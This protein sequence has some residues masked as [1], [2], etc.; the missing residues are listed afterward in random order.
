MRRIFMLD[1]AREQCPTFDHL[2][3]YAMLAAESGYDAL[4]L[5][6]EHRF[7]FACTPWA[8]GFGAITPSMIQ[9]LQSEFPSLEII[10]FIN[11]LGHM[12]GFMRTEE[13]REF[14]EAVFHGLQ[15][16]P[17]N[18]EFVALCHQMVEEIMEVF[19]SD[20]I[21]LGGDETAQLN[22][23][24]L[25]QERSEGKAEDRKAWIYAQHFAPLIDQVVKA[26][27]TPAIWADMVLEHPDVKAML[28]PETVLFDWQ[29]ETGVRETSSR[30][31]GFR[32]YGCPTLHVYNA[33]WLH[34]EGSERNI[35]Q[36]AQDVHD[37][38]LEGFCLTLWEGACFAPFD[39]LFPAIKWSA[40]A[41]LDPAGAPPLIESFGDQQEWAQL[42]GVDLE[43]IGGVFRFNKLRNPLKARFLLYS[44]PFLTWMHHAD[45]L[46][47]P[48]GDRALDLCA[49]AL[50]A[51]PGEATQGVSV[52]VRSV[53]EFVRLSER[54]RAAYSLG[55]TEHAVS[56]M[57][58]MRQLFDDLEKVAKRNHARIGGSLA[59]IERVRQ[60][61]RHVEV[62]MQRV[63]NYG[64]RQ[65]GYLP[66]WEVITNPRFT[67]HDQGCWWL[68]NKWAN[69]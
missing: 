54:A 29:Y 15:A 19:S 10:P 7:A 23:C 51:S 9:R 22:E 26:G 67:P 27:R 61:K 48:H 62:V 44:N 6:L 30:L 34:V 59:D 40:E 24:S 42:M 12:E 21:H 4:G 49:R 32:V 8:H 38:G 63:R 13:G 53:V 37:L 60:A 50:H 57:A 35:R 47:G 64:D 28:P 39:T 43:Q 36:V 16:C 2:V 31:E 68:V 33:P 1:L 25:C 46:V 65:L 66:A 69:E 58:P 14:K 5:Y 55:E 18:L 52:Y 11:L 17:T 45:Q 3:S 20:M 56:S 41:A